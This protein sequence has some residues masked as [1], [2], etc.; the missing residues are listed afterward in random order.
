M[1]ARTASGSRAIPPEASGDMATAS[2]WG[3]ALVPEAEE[4]L[5]DRPAVV[6]VPGERRRYSGIACGREIPGQN[7]RRFAEGFAGIAEGWVVRSRAEPVPLDLPLECLDHRCEQGGRPLRLEHAR[8]MRDSVEP[9]DKP[10]GGQLF[11]PD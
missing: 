4:R 6:G 3:D 5:G 7:G 8:I 9:I 11:C 10:S 1:L 2:R